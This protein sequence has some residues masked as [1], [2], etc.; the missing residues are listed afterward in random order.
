MHV[1]GCTPNVVKQMFGF[2]R[3]S[4]DF[5][6]LFVEVVKNR[7]EPLV[8]HHHNVDKREFANE[9]ILLDETKS[10]Q[11]EFVRQIAI[12][13][14]RRQQVLVQ[15]TRTKTL[16]HDRKQAKTVTNTS[17]SPKHLWTISDIDI[18]VQF[19]IANPTS[20]NS[21]ETR[22]HTRFFGGSKMS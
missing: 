7:I 19:E 22:R 6:R 21:S 20:H 14:Q 15:R 16:K 18:S 13:Q 3:N 17:A 12:V 9:T 11:M 1:G 2:L 5:F 8:C 4:Y 10:I